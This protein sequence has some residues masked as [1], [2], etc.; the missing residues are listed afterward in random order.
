MIRK[1]NSIGSYV[2]HYIP[3]KDKVEGVEENHTY[4]VCVEQPASSG[5]EWHMVMTKW[6]GKGAK[7]DIQD[8]DGT[9]HNFSVNRDG[10]YII[11]EVSI[12]VFR[13]SG[14]RYWTEIKLPATNPEEI[15]TIE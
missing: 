10:F 2:W 3:N 8:S 14:V 11:D 9:W 12:R 13:I 1:K 15:L 6:F 4:I 5:S 7:L